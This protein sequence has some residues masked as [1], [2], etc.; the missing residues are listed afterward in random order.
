MSLHYVRQ[1]I[2]DN[3]VDYCRYLL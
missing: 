3:L 1:W 2:V